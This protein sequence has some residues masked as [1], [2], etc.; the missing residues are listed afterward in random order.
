MAQPKQE[1]GV[2]LVSSFTAT[3]GASPLERGVMVRLYDADRRVIVE[4]EVTFEAFGQTATAHFE[5]PC[6]IRTW[7]K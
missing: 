2:L 7:K 1:P 5:V 4:A 3:G 6:S